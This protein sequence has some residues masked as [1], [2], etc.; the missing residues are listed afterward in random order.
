MRAGILGAT[1]QKEIHMTI[2]TKIISREIPADIIYEDDLCLAFRDIN[3]QAPTHVLIIPKEQIASL[4]DM[5]SSH[6]EIMGHLL[7]KVPEIAKSLGLIDGYRIA[8]NC[9][10]DGGQSV[11][12]LHIHL[13]GGRKMNWPPG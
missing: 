9:G 7:L 2:F 10:E 11:D 5:N 1:Q 6:Q 8:V 12:H 4:D 3:A 13:L